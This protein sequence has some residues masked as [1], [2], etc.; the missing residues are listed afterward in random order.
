MRTIIPGFAMKLNIELRCILF[1]L[2]SLVV[3]ASSLESICGKLM[4]E[5]LERHTIRSHSRQ[6][7]SQHKL[8]KSKGMVVIQEG[9]NHHLI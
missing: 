8:R 2:I 3:S 7:M 6:C 5:D 9:L 4:G 1:P